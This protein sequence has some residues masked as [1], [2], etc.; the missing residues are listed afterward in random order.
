[1]RFL[2]T[3]M[4]VLN[5]IRSRVVYTGNQRKSSQLR[6]NQNQYGEILTSAH[7]RQIQ[8]MRRQNIASLVPANQVQSVFLAQN[9]N[10]SS[11]RSLPFPSPSSSNSDVGLAEEMQ[12]V[13]ALDKRQKTQLPLNLIYHSSRLPETN[14]FSPSYALKSCHTVSTSRKLTFLE[15]LEAIPCEKDIL[16]LKRYAN[17]ISENGT[18]LD[19]VH[20]G[21]LSFTY[22]LKDICERANYWSWAPN[23]LS[24][25]A[26]FVHGNYGNTKAPSLTK[27]AYHIFCLFSCHV[28]KYDPEREPTLLNHFVNFSIPELL[29][30]TTEGEG[31]E[32][33]PG[34]MALSYIFYSVPVNERVVGLLRNQRVC[35]A[36]FY[37]SSN[38]MLRYHRAIWLSSISYQL[39]LCI[40]RGENI[41][42]NKS[43]ILK[44]YDEVLQS[45]ENEKVSKINKIYEFYFD[46]RSQ[47]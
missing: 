18:N 17:A 26:L 47:E 14:R 4:R 6:K 44:C 31:T 39:I 25:L 43:S 12:P 19:I 11:L 36:N 10:Y 16:T 46:L 21:L 24:F 7:I 13:K 15:T 30:K 28:C 33:D 3:T 37:R 20:A 45:H 41:E 35:G 29:T 9:E 40:K 8:F 34:V 27:Y 38:T 32:S 23:Y 22:C 5:E 2:V 1:M 42:Q